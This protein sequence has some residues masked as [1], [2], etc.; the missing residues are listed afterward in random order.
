MVDAPESSM[1]ISELAERAGVTPRTIRYYVTEGLLPAPGGRGQRRAYGPEHLARLDVIRQLK[2]AYL[3]LHEIRRRLD[4]P[5]SSLLSRTARPR[6]RER[7]TMVNE[8]GATSPMPA[9]AAMP[10]QTGH[11][12][13]VGSAVSDATRPSAVV[14]SATPPTDARPP[15]G[16]GGTS[17]VGRIEIYDAPETVWR[18]HVLIPG[19]ELHYRETDDRQL[20]EAIQRLIRGAVT[21]LDAPSRNRGAAGRAGADGTATYCRR[22]EQ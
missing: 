7:G 19:V 20:A 11:A 12:Q 10:A 18:R 8:V 21:M 1:G 2:A 22:E 3:P 13:A 15:I 16:F 5:T 17:G 14:A 6:T 9:S 4:D